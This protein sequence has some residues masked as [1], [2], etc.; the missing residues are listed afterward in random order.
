[1]AKILGI[2]GIFFRGKDHAG[3]KAWYQANLGIDG[4]TAGCATF[5]WRSIDEPAR[6]EMTVWSIFKQDSTYFGPANPSFMINYIVDDLVEMLD[7]LR[8]KGL[9]V[10]Q[11]EESEYGHFGWVT[12]PEGNKIELWQP[13]SKIAEG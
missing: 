3:L 12:D 10:E 6:E 5:P 2:G 11:G 1:M 9:V 7:E 13:P 8:A 4:I